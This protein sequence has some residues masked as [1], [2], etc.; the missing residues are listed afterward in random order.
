[1]PTGERIKAYGK[2]AAWVVAGTTAGAG[3][4]W[5]FS[6]R[7]EATAR[8]AQEARIA[9]ISEAMATG[10]IFCP[11]SGVGYELDESDITE[12]SLSG[13]VD[14]VFENREDLARSVS[15]MIDSVEATEGRPNKFLDSASYGAALGFALSTALV[16]R[17]VQDEAVEIASAQLPGSLVA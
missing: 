17:R 9:C 14:Q 12:L 6:V 15:S 3:A 1:M 2:Q 5:L 8:D 4:A 11:D 13:Y 7:A 16:L 10:K